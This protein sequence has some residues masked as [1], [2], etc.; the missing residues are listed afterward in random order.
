MNEDQIIEVLRR[1]RKDCAE[2][3]DI[4]CRLKAD[5]ELNAGGAPVA[6]GLEA[7]AALLARIVPALRALPARPC[8]GFVAGPRRATATA[9]LRE[10]GELLECALVVERELREYGSRPPVCGANGYARYAMGAQS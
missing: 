4:C 6:G 5:S 9:L 7:V 8:A 10:I 2:L 3:L 1:N